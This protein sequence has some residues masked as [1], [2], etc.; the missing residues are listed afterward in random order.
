MNKNNR[1]NFLKNTTLATIGLSSAATSAKGSRLQ[2]NNTPNCAPT[3]LDYF[4][5]GP[6][7]S[8]NPPTLIYNKLQGTNENG[9][10]LIIS[11]RVLDLSCNK[12]IPNAKIDIWHAQPN[13]DYDNNGFNFRG[14]TQSNEQGFYLF[15]TL[16]PGKYLNGNQFRPSH[17]HFK[18]TAPGF[19]TLTTQ[20]YF[21]GDEDIPIDAAASITSGNFDASN[22]IISLQKNT[23]NQ[24]EGTWDI[25]INGE[26]LPTGIVDLHINKGMIYELLPTPFSKKLTIKYGVFKA[27]K[28]AISVYNL[29]GKQISNLESSTMSPGKYEA[30]WEVP[31]T[32]PQGHY[33]VA[34]SINDLQVHYLKA[35]KHS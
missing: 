17:I 16:K 24:L 10:P 18:I 1:R 14:V 22:R 5:E 33:F 27:S 15:E 13:G 19:S 7:Y 30:Y 11:G 31:D 23:A 34:L 26:G 3:T 4:G 12:Y 25:V 35:L 28:V 29:M 21:E 20:L 2:Q 6:F 8:D 32:I 9:E